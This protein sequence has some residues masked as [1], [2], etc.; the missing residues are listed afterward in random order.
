MTALKFLTE[1]KQIRDSKKLTD[2][3]KV[4]LLLI[5]ISENLDSSITELMGN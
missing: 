5:H 2:D 3:Q 1:L 4:S